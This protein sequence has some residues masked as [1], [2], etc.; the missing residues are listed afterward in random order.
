[1]TETEQHTKNHQATI[2]WLLLGGMA[3][4]AVGFW[5]WRRQ[6]AR[7]ASPLIREGERATALI[8]GASSGIGRAYAV[9][10]AELGYDVILVARRR[11]MLEVLASELTDTYGVGAAVV[12]AD[13][14]TEEGICRVERTIETADGLTLLV[15]N[16]GFGMVGAFAT[17]D[18]ARHLDMIQLHVE[19]VV[20]LT[21]AALPGM[22][23]QRRG[24]IV[25]V[26]SLMAFFPLYGSTTYGAT[27]CYLQVFTEALHQELVGTGVRVQA[28]CPGFV[29][30][31]LQEV[32]EIE[33]LPVP[34]SLWMSA[35]TV[36]ARSLEDLRND[37]VISVPGLGYRLLA[38]VSGLIP[39]PVMRLAG[40]LIGQSRLS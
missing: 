1:M 4:A 16:A 11:A 9:A 21:R 33:R 19:T 37:R 12:E 6:Q 38:D 22:L 10:L 7:G 39:R 35:E 31:E 30:T 27:K 25:N 17:G 13:L 24:T 28:L 26:A 23:A 29:A 32:C 15:N 40:R 3:G 34:D 8:T 18:M 2:P 20:R 14:V 36:V 5:S